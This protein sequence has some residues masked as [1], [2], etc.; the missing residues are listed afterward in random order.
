MIDA[1]EVLSSLKIGIIVTG[2]NC[3]TAVPRGSFSTLRQK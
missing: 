1:T 2:L 3:D